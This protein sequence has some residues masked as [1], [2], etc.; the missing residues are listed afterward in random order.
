MF[1]KF[2]NGKPMV[3]L[4]EPKFILGVAEILTFGAE[5]YGPNNWKEAQPEDIQRYKDALMR[6]LLSYLDGEEIDPES[7]KPHLWH[8]AC[9]TMFLDYFDRVKT[10]HAPRLAEARTLASIEQFGESPRDE[11]YEYEHSTINK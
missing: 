8:I 10:R 4:V 9:N 6:H 7:G 2:D 3:S 1:K 5:K 11:H